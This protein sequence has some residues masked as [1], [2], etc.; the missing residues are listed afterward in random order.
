[1]FNGKKILITGGT[2]S[3][4]NELTRQILEK[5]PK[6]IRIL[7]RGEFAQ[8]SMQRKFNDSRLKTGNHSFYLIV[9]STLFIFFTSHK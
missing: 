3:W 8:V 2:G 5:N 4:G 9:L 6:E 1:M 7:S